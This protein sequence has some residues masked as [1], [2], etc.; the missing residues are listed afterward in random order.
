MGVAGCP[1]CNELH[2]NTLHAHSVAYHDKKETHLEYSTVS[3]MAISSL[4][5][6]LGPRYTKLQCKAHILRQIP[7]EANCDPR[8]SRRPSSAVERRRNIC[9]SG[10]GKFNRGCIPRQSSYLNGLHGMDGSAPTGRG[11]SRL[12]TYLQRHNIYDRPRQR[13]SS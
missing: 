11:E 10:V 8:C 6:P 3:F 9:T 2:R 12:A 1:A 7:S 4:N 5:P 13:C